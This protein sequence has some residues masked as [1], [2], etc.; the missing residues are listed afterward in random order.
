[1]NSLS[2]SSG[3]IQA[4]SISG[5]KEKGEQVDLSRRSNNELIVSISHTDMNSH[6]ILSEKIF[7]DIHCYPCACK[8][9]FGETLDLGKLVLEEIFEGI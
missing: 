9:S 6:V 3:N 7:L 1:M 4:Q 5:R 8:Q 2:G